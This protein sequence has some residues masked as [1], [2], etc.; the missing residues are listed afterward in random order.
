MRVAEQ[1]VFP[2]VKLECFTCRRPESPACY[3][4]KLKVYGSSIRQP[5]PGEGSDAGGRLPQER[6]IVVETPAGKETRSG[7]FECRQ[8]ISISA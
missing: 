6:G 2:H 1:I 3:Y 8:R 7:G 4:I 5:S